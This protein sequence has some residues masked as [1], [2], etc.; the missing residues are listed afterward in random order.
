[1]RVTPEF[2]EQQSGRNRFLVGVLWFL[3]F[4]ITVCNVALFVR[5]NSIPIPWIQYELVTHHFFWSEDGYEKCTLHTGLRL[6]DLK[7]PL[8]QKW[9]DGAFRTRQF[10]YLIEMLSFKAEQLWLPISLK[11]RTLVAIHVLNAVLLGLLL[12]RFTQKKYVAWA[13]AILLLNSGIALNTLSFSFRNAKPLVITFFLLAGISIIDSKSG[14]FHRTW[15]HSLLFS[16]FLLLAMFTDEMSAFLFIFYALLFSSSQG[17]IAFLDKRV[18]IPLTMSLLF[19]VLLATLFASAA[20]AHFPLDQEPEN[21][22]WLK[23]GLGHFRTF[24]FLYTHS[25]LLQDNIAAL[26]FYFLPRHFGRWEGVHWDVRCVLIVLLLMWAAK[27]WL[28]LPARDKSRPLFVMFVFLLMAVLV[29]YGTLQY[30]LMP[31]DATAPTLLYFS[32]YYTYPFAVLI[33]LFGGLLLI[34]SKLRTSGQLCLLLAVT[35][36][37][38]SNYFHSLT[39]PQ[40]ALQFHQWTPDKIQIAKQILAAD[41]FRKANKSQQPIYL[42]FPTGTSRQIQPDPIQCMTPD[43]SRVYACITPILYLRY[44]EDGQFVMSAENVPRRAP[45]SPGNELLEAR[46]FY[47]VPT[48]AWLDMGKLLPF[49]EDKIQIHTVTG[50]ANNAFSLPASHNQ[51]HNLIIFIRGSCQ[52]E[53]SGNQ[54]S[55]SGSQTYGQSYQYVEIPVSALSQGEDSRIV[56][57]VN[58]DPPDQEVYICFATR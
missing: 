48:G 14:D 40:D 32:Y 7:K 18:W 4:G 38:S 57:T 3:F 21:V 16:L 39:G 17:V 50:T 56:L 49:A 20:H 26:L 34:G 29:A 5:A 23:Y 6:E 46:L 15:K 24:W 11:S 12:Q 47:D 43:V 25:T 51:S 27:L 41:A 52:I 22:G 28:S 58:P 2:L 30:P 8:A 54:N 53:L 44:L 37:S 9:V 45:S 42:S 33:T 1:M 19:F 35:L 10:S 36:V 13:A 31:D 55:I